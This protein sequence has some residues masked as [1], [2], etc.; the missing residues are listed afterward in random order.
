ML[1]TN[2]TSGFL[3][4]KLII[5]VILF[6]VA[7]VLFFLIKINL[8]IGASYK[9]KCKNCNIVVIDIDLLRADAL[10]CFKNNSHEFSSNICKFA[11]K[12]LL[13]EEN[14]SQSFWTLPSLF[15][16][17]TSLY[18]PAHGMMQQ[19]R[20]VL[21][22]GITT[23]PQ[24]FKDNGYKTIWVGGKNAATITSDNGG[25]KG[26][27]EIA[28]NYQN[29]YEWPSVLKKY[30]MDKSPKLFY[31]YSGHLHIPYLFDEAVEEINGI[32]KPNSVVTSRQE[33]DEV[34]A[35]YLSENYKTVFSDEFIKEHLR[36]FLTKN[37][38]NNKYEILK[39]Y[40]E[41]TNL[42]QDD[43][44]KL[45]NLK[46]KWGPIYRAYLQPLDRASSPEEKNKVTDFLKLLYLKRVQEVDGSLGELF[47]ILSSPR[48]SNN[49]IVVVMSDHGEEFMEH[50][51]MSHSK[52]LYNE[53][54]H[55][56]LIM[57]GPNLMPKNINLISENIDIFPTLL[58]LTG[59][60]GK[61]KMQGL[62]LL[63][64]IDGNKE[65]RAIGMSDGNTASIQDKK[66]KIIADFQPNPVKIE[67]FDLQSDP[68]E[69]NS[70]EEK[71]IIAN[72]NFPG[73]LE[74]LSGVM[75]ETKKIHDEFIFPPVVDPIPPE[76]REKMMIEGY[77]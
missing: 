8:S 44:P 16:T 52:K 64:I 53:L 72:E 51:E 32:K 6:T 4:F 12:G 77:F 63:K 42:E 48:Y 17:L 70:L 22:N 65:K 38:R 67:M 69:Q 37:I 2:N 40:Q 10:P 7:T 36:L 57:T 14:F 21:P 13:F 31:F 27:T 55:T 30:E 54:L 5:L 18:P 76:K 56:P 39:Y 3:R 15:S 71:D 33:F 50:G 35:N 49:T 20:D 75:K 19:Y 59:I 9:S 47:S 41:I 68:L 66:W 29:I 34:M 11:E 62:S 25:T 46:D 73:L 24:V 60:V 23:F 45:L 26:F 43:L 74:E 1:L 28:D 61:Q 58:D